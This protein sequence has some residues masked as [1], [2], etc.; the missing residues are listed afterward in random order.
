MVAFSSRERR[1][2][3]GG[4]AGAR[5]RWFGG[6]QTRARSGRGDAGRGQRYPWRQRLS[7]SFPLVPGRGTSR[8]CFCCVRPRTSSAAAYTGVSAW[9]KAVQMCQRCLKLGLDLDKTTQLWSRSP[10][11]RC[12]TAT[13]GGASAWRFVEGFSR[14]AWGLEGGPGV[15]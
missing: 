2:A 15:W 3:A 12:G 4:W 13:G 14:L 7:Q 1:G 11:S 9:E 5:L 10:V 6:R 8:G